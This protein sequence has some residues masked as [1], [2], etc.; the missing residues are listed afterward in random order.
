MNNYSSSIRV[1]LLKEEQNLSAY[2]LLFLIGFS[3]LGTA[4]SFVPANGDDLTLLSTVANT[5]TP[6]KFFFGDWGLGNYY[7]P[8]HSLTLWFSYQFFGVSAGYNQL[9]NLILHFA[10]VCLLFR[11]I[12]SIQPDITI[13]F[14]ITSLS[15]VSIYTMSPA[16]WVS[17]RPTLFV[18]L[19]F[20]LLLNH[21]YKNG[22]PNVGRTSYI[23]ILSILAL[24]SKESGLIV[25]L[26]ILYYGVCMKQ[27]AKY[28]TKIIIISLIIIAAYGTFRLMIFGL[29]TFSYSETGYMF[30]VI[31]IDNLYLLPKYLQYYVYLENVIK[32]LI[33]P[34][35]PVFNGEGGILSIR[36][37]IRWSPLWSLTLILVALTTRKLSKLSSLQKVALVI[38]V[39]NSLIHTSVFRY[40]TQYLSQLAICIFVASSPLLLNST[41]NRK[42]VVNILAIALLLF[43]I[44]G[45]SRS[46]NSTL[47]FRYEMLNK[48]DLLPI[49]KACSP[50]IDNQ[51]VM[52]V[53]KKY[54]K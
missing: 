42:F 25:P 3:V 10:I 26:F 2:A 41:I 16:T 53:L 18:A 51:I 1:F 30:G 7:R 39:L 49:I 9:L 4:L 14:L 43:N 40:R 5:P 34:I 54:K 21:L 50:R 8:L 23:V 17:D 48:Y 36:A 13:S 33:A 31:H 32:N 22:Q 37:L 44:I 27:P 6:I 24:M 29:H 28:R 15:L 38:I 35:F 19:F 46:L 52:Q 12:R 11:L 20:L 45:V 47:L